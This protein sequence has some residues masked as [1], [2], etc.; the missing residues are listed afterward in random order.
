MELKLYEIA[1][2]MRELMEAEDFDSTRFDELSLAFE[3][4]A[5]GVNYYIKELNAFVAMAKEEAKRVTALA[6]AAEKRAD[7][8]K[9]Y[10]KNCMEQA[11]IYELK[12]DTV[13]FKIKKNPPAVSID[14][15]E[16]VPPKYRVVEVV[17]KIDNRQLLTDLK[18]GKE[19]DGCTLTQG[20]RLDIK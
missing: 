2:S 11:E 4:K 6:K 15:E 14:N 16:I 8:L 18:A 20:T 10:I 12:T 5:L 17:K 9:R 1:P 7:Q 19:I 3:S 13:T